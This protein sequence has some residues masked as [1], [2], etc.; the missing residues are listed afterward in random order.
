MCENIIIRN[1]LVQGSKCLCRQS[2]TFFCFSNSCCCTRSCCWWDCLISPSSSLC[3]I[4]STSSS[5]LHTIKAVAHTKLQDRRELL[6]WWTSF[7]N[8]HYQLY[9]ICIFVY[10]T[11]CTCIIRFFH[12]WEYVVGHTGANLRFDIC[13]L[14]ALLASSRDIAV[15]WCN[16]LSLCSRASI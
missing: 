16:S 4:L 3:L 5:L 11:S 13:S 8:S 12:L 6:C 2:S 14:A 1:G 7:G 15:D 9:H 10:L